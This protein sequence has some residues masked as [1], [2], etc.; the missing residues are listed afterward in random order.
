M[1]AKNSPLWVV[2]AS[3]SESVFTIRTILLLFA[4]SR[5][6][7]N[8]NSTCVVSFP[9]FANTSLESP[10]RIACSSISRFVTVPTIG[11][12]LMC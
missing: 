10:P 6:L 7:C 12:R 1:I 11:R 8:S 2:S 9:Q 5:G 4:Q 3:P